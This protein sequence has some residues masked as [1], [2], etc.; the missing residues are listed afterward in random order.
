MDGNFWG[1]IE[2]DRPEV[3]LRVG[4]RPAVIGTART[5]LPDEWP[6]EVEPMAKETT[7]QYRV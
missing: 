2:K 6:C 5:R 7:N 3:P 4:G 1:G